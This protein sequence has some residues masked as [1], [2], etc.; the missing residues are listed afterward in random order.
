MYNLLRG[1]AP[2]GDRAR[3]AG[4][5]DIYMCTCIHIYIYIERERDRERCEFHVM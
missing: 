4:P 3:A 2:P 1:R 5:R